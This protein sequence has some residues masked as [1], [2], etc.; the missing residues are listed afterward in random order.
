MTTITNTMNAN[1]P[2]TTLT[3]RWGWLLALG[4]VQIAQ[5]S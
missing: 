4:V 3:Q 2:A 1:A 5:G